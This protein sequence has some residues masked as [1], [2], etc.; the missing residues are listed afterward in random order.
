MLVAVVTGTVL[1]GPVPEGLRTDVPAE[2]ITPDVQWPDAEV[3]TDRAVT[4]RTGDPSPTAVDRTVSGTTGT[5]STAHGT[6]R[7]RA[8]SLARVPVT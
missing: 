6:I 5:V 1:I 7:A 8:E 4:T 2:E 3:P